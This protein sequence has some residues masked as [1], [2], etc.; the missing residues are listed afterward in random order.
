M[1]RIYTEDELAYRRQK[2]A[3]E[4]LERNRKTKLALAYAACL[5]GA[6]TLVLWA[7][8]Q[9][10]AANWRT[11]KTGRACA[12]A[13]LPHYFENWRYALRIVDCETGHTY[14]GRTRG[15]AGERGW[16][17]I[18]PVHFGWLDENRLWDVRYN[19]SIARRLSRH[20]RDWSPWTCARY[21]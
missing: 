1:R 17:Q 9:A 10:Q 14:S 11:C 13:V 5:L 3:A 19:S 20:G 18:H 4:E 21:V 15:S 7:S 8:C 2:K 16:F 12:K 6:L